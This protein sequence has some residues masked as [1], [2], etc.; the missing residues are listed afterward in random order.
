MAGLGTDASLWMLEKRNLQIAADSAVIAAGWEL[1]QENE[2]GMDAA[3]LREALNNGYKPDSNGHHEISIVDYTDEGVILSVTLEQDAE[4]FFSKIFL[5]DPFK[6]SVQAQA[7]I[8][9]PDGKFCILAL[10]ENDASSFKTQG[11]AT[12]D[13]PD[14][15]IAVNSHSDEAMTMRGNVNIDVGAVNITGNYDIDGMVDFTY[16]SLRTG[17][18]P[19]ID[20]YEDLRVPEHEDC[21]HNNTRIN[22]STTLRPGVYCGGIRIS[23]NNDIILEPGVYIIDGGD[24]DIAGSGILR[25]EGVTIILTGEGNDYAGVDI[26]GGREVEL[27][28]PLNGED[29]EGIVFFQDREAP[30]RSNL[31]NKIVGTSD[32]MLDGVAYFPSQGLWFGG[33]TTVLRN[34]QACTKFIARTVTLAGNPRM[35]NSCERFGVEETGMPSVKLIR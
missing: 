4:A 29:W 30:Q 16:S 6:I 1:A 13:T 5:P 34:D 2:D 21:D 9:N 7:I 25:G 22:S 35:G 26:S 32:L 31:Q 19:I 20:P 27:S 17:T 33:N 11:N 12:I 23:G 18:A 8:A 24:L 14:C 28:A 3:S 10:E 15:G